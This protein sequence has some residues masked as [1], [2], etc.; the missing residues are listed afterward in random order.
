MSQT[1]QIINPVSNGHPVGSYT[2]TL[3]LSDGDNDIVHNLG[4]DK[5]L[6]DFTKGGVEFQPAWKI[7]VG[8][9]TTTIVVSVIGLQN[10]VD[11]NIIG[12]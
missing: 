2:Q 8:S 4:T 12:I 3:N 1:T 9:E 11:V 6:V 5:L 7:K 10:D